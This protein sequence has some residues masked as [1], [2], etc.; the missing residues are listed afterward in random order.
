[1]TDERWYAELTEG[2]W[3]WTIRYLSGILT[4]E[5]PDWAATEKR[6]RKKASRRLAEL[7]APPG[8]KVTVTQ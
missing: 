5:P 7:N 8:R 2:R 1:M 3:G 6:A 4:I